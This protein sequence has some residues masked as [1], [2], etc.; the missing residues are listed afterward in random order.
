MNY[1]LHTADGCLP[2]WLAGNR[3]RGGIQAEGF[4]GGASIGII[5]LV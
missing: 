3:Y 2:N 4:F 5:I 1:T